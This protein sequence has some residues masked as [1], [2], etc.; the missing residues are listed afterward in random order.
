T[1]EKPTNALDYNLWLNEH[2]GV[3]ITETMRVEYEAATAKMKRDLEMSHFWRQLPENLREYDDQYTVEMRYPLLV[4]PPEIVPELMIKPWNTL[5]DKTYRANVVK[6]RNWPNPPED[7]WILPSNWYTRINDILRTMIVVKYLDGVAFLENK[8]KSLCAANYDHCDWEAK[9]EGYYA[10]H[11]YRRDEFEIPA[12]FFDTQK[13]SVLIEIQIT[14]QIQ[15]VI[16][17]LLWDYYERSRSKIVPSSEI[18]WQWEW[19]TDKFMANYLGHILH[20]LEGMIME[21]RDKEKGHVGN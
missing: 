11:L 3:E 2:V 9:E 19:K 10:V 5:V 8:L 16:R 4:Y 15:E 21:I 1:S 17:K 13:V 18:V 6:N 7:G 20:Y 14:T 12:A